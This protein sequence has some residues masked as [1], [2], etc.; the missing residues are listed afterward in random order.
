MGGSSRGS[1]SG[2]A[3]ADDGDIEVK[4]FHCATILCESEPVAQATP[5]AN[6]AAVDRIAPMKKIAP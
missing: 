6:P 2:A 3:T 4:T 1:I 5:G